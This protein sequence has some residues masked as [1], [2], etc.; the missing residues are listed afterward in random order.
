MVAGRRGGYVFTPNVDHVVLAEDLAELRQAYAQ[1]NLVVADGQPL[2]WASWL[3]G[4]RLPEKVSG[5]DLVVPLAALAARRHFRVYLIGGRPGVAERAGRALTQ[6][7]PALR[8]VGSDSPDVNLDLPTLQEAATLR[9][10]KAVR[11]DLILV[12]FGSPKQELW[13]FRHRQDLAPGIAIGVGAAFDFL[14]GTVRRAPRFLSKLGLE[15]FFRLL[16]EPL[17]L[18]PRYFLRDPRFLWIM[19]R[20][21]WRTR[22]LY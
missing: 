2:L 22:C 19:L 6:R 18:A 9:R 10:L 17:R 12:A 8:V 3:M 16:H 20:Q 14:A 4:Q 15:W 11:P 13:I 7:F 21:W 5:S 1:A